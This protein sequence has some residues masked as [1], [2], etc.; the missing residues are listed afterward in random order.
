M[1]RYHLTHG[2]TLRIVI[3]GFKLH[4][5]QIPM[6]VERFGD[7]VCKV[8][9]SVVANLDEVVG[10]HDRGNRPIDS[11]KQRKR[12]GGS[13]ISGFLGKPRNQ[14]LLEVEKHQIVQLT[15]LV[16][17]ALLGRVGQRARAD[18]RIGR[19]SLLAGEAARHDA[20]AF[21]L[22]IFGPDAVVFENDRL[23]PTIQVGCARSLICRRSVMPDFF[24]AAASI[25]VDVL[26]TA[27]TR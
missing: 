23:F 9:R 4:P 17:G 6:L 11:A 22:K 18:E 5:E 26:I 13:L 25:Y 3:P 27:M 24:E 21:G 8:V 14:R 1:H 15:R 16:P 20:T 19:C 7:G 2:D 10:A 12:H